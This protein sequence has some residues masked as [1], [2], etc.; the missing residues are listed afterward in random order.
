M[1]VAPLHS[2]CVQ[3]TDRK[4]EA[5]NP[6]VDAAGHQQRLIDILMIPIV[7]LKQKQL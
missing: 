6:G 1:C 7:V 3:D 2:Y 4:I 5:T